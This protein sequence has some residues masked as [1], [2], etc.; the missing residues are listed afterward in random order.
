MISDS[1][2]AEII[3]QL[4]NGRQIVKTLLDG[5]A[6][7][8]D[9][10]LPFLCLYRRPTDR[11][12]QG[13]ARLLHSE[14][15]YIVADSDRAN[16][17]QLATLCEAILA[18][19]QQSF[20][21]VLLLEIWSSRDRQEYSER[22]AFRIVAHQHHAPDMLLE[23]FESALLTIEL[24][25]QAAIVTIDY[26]PEIAP[27]D[28]SP[29]LTQVQLQQLK[30]T[31]IGLEI[32]PVYQDPHNRELFPFELKELQHALSVV[33]KRC[34]YDFIRSYTDLRPTHFLELGRQAMTDAVW[35][36]DRKLA[37][38]SADFDLLLH[39]TPVNVLAA[40]GEFQHH[41][42]QKRPEFLYRQRPFDPALVKRKLYDIDID[43]IEDPTLEH[44]FSE[45][46]VELDRQITLVSDRNTNRFILGSRQLFG[47]VDDALL[48]QAKTLLTQLSDPM[49]PDAERNSVSPEQFA[50]CAR[51]E[52]DHYRQ[53]QPDFTARVDL[54]SDISGIL[55]SNGNLL[56]GTDARIAENRVQALLAHEVGTHLVTHFNGQQ[57]GFR[58]LSVG[59]AGYET[60]QEGL[61]VL[62]EYL[63]AGL[64]SHRLRVLAGRVI[65]VQAI[66]GGAEFVETFEQLCKEYDFVAATAF[67]ITMRVYRGGGYTK[68]LIYLKG[69]AQILDFLANDGDLVALYRGKI[70][71]E[72]LAF[73]EELSW[74]KI[75]KPAALKPHCLEMP[76]AKQRLEILRGGCTLQQLVE[77]S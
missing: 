29:I 34:F 73:I 75:V 45:K 24:N 74:R 3:D 9:R 55:V 22:P 27:P 41:D 31:N 42:F 12:D 20:S 50:L 33:L 28:L 47:D 23:Q 10:P 36:V 38:I 65:A 26:Q 21:G 48:A 72:Y 40:W 37:A 35:E 60:L 53:Q 58:E 15:A 67:Y 62:A 6:V 63:V 46:R 2:I 7:H 56:I 52:I 77:D 44:I 19:K 11:W 18:I 71:M 8:I 76:E 64:D 66:T 51:K 5:T 43:S 1:E 30:C 61:A 70:T 39:V 68:D 59:M 14:S 13:T 49:I 25:G 57:Q 32:S 16:H 54:R 17:T 69:L 4:S